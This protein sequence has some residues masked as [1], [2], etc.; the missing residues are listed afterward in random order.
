M[1]FSQLKELDD[2]YILN[3]YKRYPLQVVRGEGVYV[4][5]EKGNRYLDFLSGIAVN[6]LGYGHPAIV[7]AIKAQAEKLIHISNLF[8]TEPP[9]LLARKLTELSG[10]EKAFFC[11]SGAEANELAIKLSRVHGRNLKPEK[12]EIV[13]ML[14]SF[15]GRT[16]ATLTI[17][18]NHS[19][20]E[21]FYPL[22]EGAVF[23]GLNDD[24]GLRAVVNE[25]TACIIIEPV[26]GEGGVY[27]ATPEFLQLA[28]QLAD[29]YDALL[30][31]DEVQCGLGR[32][33][34]YFAHEHAGIKPDI[35]TLAKP[36]GAGLP[37]GAV[38]MT[39]KI[40]NLLTYGDHGSTFGANCIAIAAA[41]A[42][43]KVLEE[44]NL[45]EHVREISGYLM[46]SLLALKQQYPYV[47]EVRGNGL[48]IG[49][50]LEMPAAEVVAKLLQEGLIVNC[51]AE[52]V[53]RLLPPYITKKE[54]VDEAMCII[55]KVFQTITS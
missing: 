16:C 33:G 45:L 23:A 41:R 39:D 18:K 52:K 46:D 1:D 42:F 4:Y 25:K 14:N 38:L 35:I 37:A 47:K 21:K 17:T 44:E 29:Q 10:L 50:E 27:A 11:N 13:S 2:M 51:T 3:S 43:L 12:I 7:E 55:N 6:A 31:M 5:D 20:G 40:A 34:N 26:Q 36:L 15:H 49:L 48:I 53:I 8:Y 32:T 54:H 22:I 28:R 19:Y 24:D 30:V 9:V